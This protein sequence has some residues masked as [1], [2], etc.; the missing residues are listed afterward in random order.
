MAAVHEHDFERCLRTLGVLTPFRL[1]ELA[2]SVC[3][4]PLTRSNLGAFG[5]GPSSPLIVCTGARCISG[6]FEPSESTRQESLNGE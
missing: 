2:C 1:G 4:T 5:G 3:G 6:C